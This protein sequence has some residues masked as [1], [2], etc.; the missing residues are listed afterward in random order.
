MGNDVR[1]EAVV[2]NEM[3]RTNSEWFE[4]DDFDKIYDEIWLHE[5]DS[6]IHL[7]TEL[8]C[9][10]GVNPLLYL[11]RI[12]YCFM[13]SGDA[14]E[15]G[16]Q[17]LRIGGD[18]EEILG[19]AFSRCSN[20]KSVYISTTKPVIIGECAFAQCKDLELVHIEKNVTKLNVHQ[21]AYDKKL[22]TV[23][24]CEGLEYIGNQAFQECKALKH[25]KL[26]NSLTHIGQDCFKSSGLE[27]ITIPGSVEEIPLSCFSGCEGL[28]NLTIKNG[29]KKILRDALQGTSVQTVHIPKSVEFIDQYFYPWSTSLSEIK[30]DGTMEQFK[31]IA[32][33]LKLY[34][35]ADIICTDGTF[36]VGG[37]T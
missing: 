27:R 26:P 19:F 23:D 2:V 4:E 32:N 25:I 1:H 22:E 15:C 35:R 24:L 31:T 13:M 12:P 18:I 9:S 16:Y 14:S 17:T 8:F 36:Q 21:F 20:M 29:V 37:H 10:C 7:F 6:E 5:L 3:L 34:Q 28:S 33:G 30:Y 11:K